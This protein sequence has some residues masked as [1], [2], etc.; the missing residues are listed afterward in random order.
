MSINTPST[1]HHRKDDVVRLSSR[2][3]DHASYQ[4]QEVINTF[5]S[6]TGLTICILFKTHYEKKPTYKAKVFLER[7]GHLNA[8]C[9]LVKSSPKIKGCKAYDGIERARK[10]AIVRKPFIDECPAG[11]VE[12]IIPL[13]IRGEFV[14]TIFCGQIRKY[15][16]PDKGFEYIWEKIAHRGCNAEK[17]KQEYNGFRYYP[18]AELL[19]LGNLFFYAVS[20]IA[21]SL[22]DVAIERQI[23][24]QHN[25]LIKEAVEILQNARDGFP[26]EGEISKQLGI[27]PEYFS[28]LFKKVMN[29]SFIE[30]IIE[31]RI[32]RAQELLTNTNLPIIDIAAEVGYERQSYFTKKFKELAGITPR[33]FRAT[34][35]ILQKKR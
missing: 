13:I 33:Q 25:H 15:K 14:G 32:A 6:L 23:K 20:Y 10:A 21:D 31:L 26:S 18:D 34:S 35:N 24:L 28:K 5:E 9:T 4:F 29:K 16:N 17:L 8:F 30:Y 12:L 2:F 3:Y 1:G 22:D 11:I 27:T 19:R 7:I